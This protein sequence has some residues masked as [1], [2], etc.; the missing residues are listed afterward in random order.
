MVRHGVMPQNDIEQLAAAIM[1][2]G[3]VGGTVIE[4]NNSTNRNLT[5]FSHD[6]TSVIA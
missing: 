1:E 5:E 4:T 2:C 6:K 3:K